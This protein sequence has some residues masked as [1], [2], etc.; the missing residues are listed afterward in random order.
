[1]SSSNKIIL[2]GTG[3]AGENQSLVY[4]WLESNAHQWCNIGS[5]AGTHYT[6]LFT[7]EFIYR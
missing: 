3:S 5:S 2:S 1:M 4:N 7:E 6:R